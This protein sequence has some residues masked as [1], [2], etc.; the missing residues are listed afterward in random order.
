MFYTSLDNMIR[1]TRYPE[2][3]L[4]L[5]VEKDLYDGIVKLLPE[6]CPPLDHVWP[7]EGINFGKWYTYWTHW[8]IVNCPDPHVYI[9]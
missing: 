8:A 1:D 2:G 4:L 7:P 6:H 9:R 3:L 5:F